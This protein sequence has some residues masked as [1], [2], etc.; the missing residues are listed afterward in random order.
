VVE[1]LS[2]KCE[3]LSVSPV[4]QERK[5]GRKEGRG[6]QGRGKGVK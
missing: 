6:G 1:L 3:T 4:L 2:S 5:E